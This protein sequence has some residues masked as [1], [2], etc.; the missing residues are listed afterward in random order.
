MS[1]PANQV[2]VGTTQTNVVTVTSPGVQGPPGP[3]A[4]PPVLVANLGTPTLGL[5]GFVTDSTSSVYG[6]I[7]TGGGFTPTPVFADGSAW[8]IG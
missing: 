6:A 2:F 7:V 3:N 4:L 8:R 5:L 1:T